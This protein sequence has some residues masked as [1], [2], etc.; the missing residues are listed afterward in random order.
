[1]SVPPPFPRS[2]AAAVDS[3]GALGDKVRA[4]R[5]QLRAT[6]AE[7]ADLAGVGVRFL[8]ELERGKPSVEFGKVLRVL[9][10]LGLDL[11]VKGRSE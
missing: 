1:M 8:S 11:S 3:V 4:K 7:V 2:S 9:S 5:R 6:Q 10:A